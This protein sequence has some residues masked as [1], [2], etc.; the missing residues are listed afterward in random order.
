MKHETLLGILVYT[1]VLFLRN[2]CV[3]NVNLSDNALYFGT[4]TFKLAQ[5]GHQ[6]VKEKP[7]FSIVCR[8]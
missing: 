1:F 7:I 3:L 4:F 5:N 6:N 2:L 8:T